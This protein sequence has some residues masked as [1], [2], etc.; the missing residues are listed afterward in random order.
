MAADKKNI[1]K[2]KAEPSKLPE[3]EALSA[4]EVEKRSIIW[5]LGKL[6]QLTPT[7]LVG[8]IVFAGSV[9]SG[10]FAAGAWLSDLKPKTEEAPAP[11]VVIRTVPE[12][13]KPD[14]LRLVVGTVILGV[15]QQPPFFVS[16]SMSLSKISEGQA[17]IN[18]VSLVVNAISISD[19]SV[20]VYRTD[21]LQNKKMKKDDIEPI[22]INTRSSF[23]FIV[24]CFVFF[25]YVSL[26]THIFRVFI[27]VMATDAATSKAIALTIEADGLAPHELRL[28]V[29]GHS[30]LECH[31]GPHHLAQMRRVAGRSRVET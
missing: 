23:F 12:P 2:G 28:L 4:E 29:R 9:L 8:L 27:E 22:E 15:K 31:C 6:G 11:K 13:R 18:R 24:L 1:S 5:W 19:G 3:P 17:L 10:T 30:H 21:L 20:L 25:I 14:A 7:Q 16:T 26:Q